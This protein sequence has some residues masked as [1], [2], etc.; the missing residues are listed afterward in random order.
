MTKDEVLKWLKSQGTSKYKDGLSRYGIVTKRQVFGVSVGAMQAFAKR[1]GKDHKLAAELWKSGWYEG[2][3]LAVMVE[4]PA[5]VTPRQMNSW[6]SDFD[7]WGIV[8]TACFHLFD[9]TPHAWDKAYEWAKSPREFVRRASFALMAS[10]VVHDK[11]A[12]D[13]RF[14]ELLPLIEE[15]ANDDRNFVKKGVNWALRCIGK[16]SLMLNKAAVATS[17]RLAAAEAPAPRWVGKDALRELT[18]E[19]LQTRLK[20]KAKK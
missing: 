1:I 16:R 15:G 19:K 11:K 10:L 12:P 6:A 17:K 7:N 13:E 14:L 18:A 8:D 3:M 20:K 4:D 5:K 9:K 2:Q